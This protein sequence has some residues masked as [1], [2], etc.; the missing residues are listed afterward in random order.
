MGTYKLLLEESI[1]YDFTLIA[2]HG[3]L[4][5]FYIAYI[6][7]KHLDIQLARTSNDLI[8]AQE[9]ALQAA[10]TCFEYK[11]VFRYI[12]YYVFENKVKTT[13][14]KQLG[15]GLFESEET[16]QTQYFIPEM[17]QADY[18]IKVIEDGYAFA[19]AKT[20]KT[21]NQIPQIV[22]AYDVDVSRLKTK[23]NLIFE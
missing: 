13:H 1:G 2:L 15:K 23:Q 22:T 3:S 10:Y 14:T 20:L 6:L 8:I 7:N 18:F 19:K 21:L 5:P 4:E 12:D 9:A 17:P 11:D 16:V